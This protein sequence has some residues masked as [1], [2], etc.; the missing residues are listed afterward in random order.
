MGWVGNLPALTGT[1]KD[2]PRL[3]LEHV[4]CL[5]RGE[6]QVERRIGR[7]PCGLSE[8]GRC[9]GKGGCLHSGEVEGVGIRKDGW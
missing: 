2:D 5:L 9:G 1:D 3:D 7:W 8:K 4:V 6:V